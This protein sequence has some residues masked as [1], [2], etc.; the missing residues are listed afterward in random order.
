[1]VMD[2]IFG[3]PL[4]CLRLDQEPS[5]GY[6][7]AEAVSK[8]EEDQLLLPEMSMDLEDFQFDL[9]TISDSLGPW[10]QT[11]ASADTDLLL[12]GHSSCKSE[13]ID[14]EDLDI[15]EAVRYDCMWST[16]T[17]TAATATT[18]KSSSSCSVAIPHFRSRN[19]ST[20]AAGASQLSLPFCENALLDEFLRLLD[21]PPTGPP[22]GSGGLDPLDCVKTEVK[23]EDEEEATTTEEEEDEERRSRAVRFTSLDHCYISSAGIKQEEAYQ[24]LGSANLNIDTPPESSDDDEEMHPA[25]AIRHHSQYSSF[26]SNSRHL[27]HHHHHNNNNNISGGTS[28]LKKVNKSSSCSSSFSNGGGL[29]KFSFRVKLKTDSSR[30]VLKHHIRQTARSSPLKVSAIGFRPAAVT[31][32]TTI[33]SGHH[34]HGG[35][36]SSLQ[37]GIR[38]RKEASLKLKHDEARE[39]HNQMERQRRNELKL[40]FDDLKASIADIAASDKVSKQMILDKAVE[41]CQG[42][43]TREAALRQRRERLRR[44]NNQLRERLRALQHQAFQPPSASSPPPPGF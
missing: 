32:T 14:F 1:M 18:A 26:N 29:A 12:H 5:L 39:V 44:S 8:E 6:M 24:Q 34:H 21:T 4:G 9:D 13:P 36:G 15:T 11:A 16:T 31:T 20:A 2:Q 25:T 37:A 10:I 35:S 27:H 38:R 42:L 41:R 33:A 43:R 22:G 19:N 23:D 30:S 7:M 28:L 3:G 17:A 40:A